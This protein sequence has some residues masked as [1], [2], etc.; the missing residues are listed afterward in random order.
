MMLDIAVVLRFRTAEGDVLR[1]RRR[2]RRW[3]L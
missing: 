3:R 2:W 1:R